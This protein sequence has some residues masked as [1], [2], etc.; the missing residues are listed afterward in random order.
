MSPR[1]RRDLRRPRKR[2]PRRRPRPPR[3]P[4]RLRAPVSRRRGTMFDRSSRTTGERSSAGGT[5]R[6]TICGVRWR[7]C[8]RAT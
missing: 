8:G 3:R 5:A 7:R 4:Q 6:R 2:P 1:R